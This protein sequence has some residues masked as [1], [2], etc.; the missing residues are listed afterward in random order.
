MTKMETYN[1]LVN[2]VKSPKRDANKIAHLYTTCT[3]VFGMKLNF[4]DFIDPNKIPDL[5]VKT[6]KEWATERF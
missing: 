3:S 5:R 1:A 4:R 2:A 6:M